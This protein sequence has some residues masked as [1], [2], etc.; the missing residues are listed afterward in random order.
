MFYSLHSRVGKEN[1]VFR[2]F[3][4]CFQREFEMYLRLPYLNVFFESKILKYQKMLQVNIEPIAFIPNP[5]T[6]I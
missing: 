3:V 5:A 4:L 6:S 1:L 2:H